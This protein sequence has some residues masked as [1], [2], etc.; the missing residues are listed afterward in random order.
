MHRLLEQRPVASALFL[1]GLAREVGMPHANHDLLQQIAA[2]ATLIAR[3]DERLAV[4]GD[5]GLRALQRLVHGRAPDRSV[6]QVF[7]QFMSH[8]TRRDLDRS[9]CRA[10]ARAPAAQAGPVEA[11][12]DRSGNDAE[13]A[14]LTRMRLGSPLHWL[15][16]CLLLAAQGRPADAQP[17]APSTTA[18][19]AVPTGSGAAPAPRAMLALGSAAL[20]TTALAG[21]TLW[22]IHAGEAPDRDA[23]QPESMAAAL[24]AVHYLDQHRGGDQERLLDSLVWCSR[25]G[26][27]D[28][29]PGDVLEPR[30]LAQLADMIGD[31]DAVGAWLGAMLELDHGCSASP[32][33]GPAARLRLVRQASHVS[34]PATGAGSAL[35]QHCQQITPG[36][37]PLATLESACAAVTRADRVAALADTQISAYASCVQRIRA[38]VM[39]IETVL[40]DNRQALQSTGSLASEI[41]R[42]Q[43]LSID[44]LLARTRALSAQLTDALVRANQRI[45]DRIG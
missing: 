22:R 4:Q 12:A 28:R 45:I 35:L 34:A 30:K 27:P 31:G 23:V 11:R 2:H 7:E 43:I 18:Y 13:R 41:N 29:I 6:A 9:T 15:T 44:R 38:G 16:G 20:A 24:Q 42:L 21:V 36:Q 26:R 10:D 32:S 37:Q 39:A 17:D 25:A 40:G 14:T 3:V 19:A 8:R 33:A 1:T 5:R